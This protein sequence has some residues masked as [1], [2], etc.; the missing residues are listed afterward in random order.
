LKNVLTRAAVCVSISAL[1]F[2]SALRA[3]GAVGTAHAHHH[4]A[5]S[6][7]A[8][9]LL[10]MARA[11]TEKFADRS[12][13]IAAGY[14]PVGGDFPSMGEHWLSPRLIVEGVFDVTRPSVLTYL[15]VDGKPILT[16]V[17]YAIP[18][19]PG[20]SPPA[21]FGS[22]AMWHEHNGSIDEES[23]LPQHHTM[24]SEAKG[25]RVAVLHAWTRVP[26]PNGIFEAENWAIPFLRAG[27]EVPDSFTEDAARAVSVT[28]HGREFFLAMAGQSSASIVASSIDEC[29]A[30]A[31][32]VISGAKAA[33]RSLTTE[34]VQLLA[35]AW[36]RAMDVIA[37]S[38]AESARKLNGGKL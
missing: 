8:A 11:A 5:V 21:A 25:T 36:R 1:A 20:E 30:T 19:A 18:L 24:P 12:V 37:R 28:G 13:A 2:A 23:L 6:D 15:T 31:D 22:D 10:D 27:L 34:D 3:Q 17:V 32:R 16:G 7:S 26:S 14:R 38:D 33:R 9:Q 4:A 29:R 35:S